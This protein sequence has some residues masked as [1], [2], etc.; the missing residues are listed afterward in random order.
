M[1]L[2]SGPVLG[3][4]TNFQR[5]LAMANVSNLFIHSVSIE[6]YCVSG[7]PVDTNDTVVNKTGVVSVLVDLFGDM[8]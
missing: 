8:E 3:V 4:N 5:I 7:T 6:H 1:S 2:E